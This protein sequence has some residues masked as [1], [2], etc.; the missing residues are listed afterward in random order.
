LGWSN[1]L[2]TKKAPV[3]KPLSTLVGG[4]NPS[5][6]YESQLGWLFQIDGKNKHVPRKTTITVNI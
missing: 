5:E 4:F 2:S 1:G 3:L 6:K